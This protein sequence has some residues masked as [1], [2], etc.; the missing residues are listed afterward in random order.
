MFRDRMCIVQMADFDISENFLSCWKH[1]KVN[2]KISMAPTPD[3]TFNILIS[4][5]YW[6]RITLIKI[7]CCPLSAFQNLT[8]LRL[9]LV[10]LFQISTTQY[11][12][13]NGPNRQL[14]VGR[15]ADQRRWHRTLDSGRMDPAHYEVQQKSSYCDVKFSYRPVNNTNRDKSWNGIH[16]VVS[17]RLDCFAVLWTG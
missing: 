11:W 12:T 8:N 10:P 13:C 1:N 3:R 17:F 2:T 9:R 6:P 16:S 4:E 15:S 14:H 5:F 7:S